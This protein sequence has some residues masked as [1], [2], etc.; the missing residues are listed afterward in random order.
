M[1]AL[2]LHVSVEKSPIQVQEDVQKHRAEIEALVQEILSFEADEMAE[3]CELMS[4]VE[5]FS[6]SLVDETQ[7]LKQFAWP[8]DK[9]SSMREAIKRDATL[10][11]ILQQQ[12]EMEQTIAALQGNDP[13][14]SDAKQV[15]RMPAR[16][17]PHRINYVVYRWSNG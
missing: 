16:P 14:W 12:Q 2:F 8:E 10:Q 4:R 7:V 9:L 15:H 13:A 6:S 17:V 5:E 3:C 11:K 1:I